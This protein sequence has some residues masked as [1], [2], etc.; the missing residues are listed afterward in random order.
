MKTKTFIKTLLLGMLLVSCGGNGEQTTPS[1]NL[2]NK[3]SVNQENITI[4]PRSKLNSSDVGDPMPFYDNGVMNI[5][6]LENF[7]T[8]G[9]GYHPISLFQTQDY[10]HYDDKGMVI[11]YENSIYSPEVALGTGSVVKKDGIYHFFYTGHNSSRSSGLPYYEKILHA[12]STDLINWTKHPEHGFYGN[13][14]DFRD[15]Y[16]F[17]NEEEQC[18]WMLITTRYRERGVLALYTST[19]PNLASWELKNPEFYVNGYE[20]YNME[21]PTLIKFNGY[22]YLSFSEQGNNRITRYRYTTSLSSTNTNWIVPEIDYFDS[23]GFYAG[24]LEKDENKLYA[25]GWCAIKEGAY[26]LGNFDWGGNLVV[27]ELTQNTY[28]ELQAKMIDSIKSTIKTEVGYKSTTT[29][30]IIKE[31][32]YNNG[33]QSTALERLSDNITRISFKLNLNKSTGV[34]GITFNSNANNR[35][36]SLAYEFDFENNKILFYNDIYEGYKNPPQIEVKYTFSLRKDISCDLIIEDEV[37]ILYVDNTIA[38]T[39]RMYEHENRQFAF[40]GDSGD[41]TIKDVKFYE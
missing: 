29:N 18:Y 17:Y 34:G 23:K 40:Y 8:M 14:N 31:Y 16:V 33:M 39:T 1:I 27:H 4:A 21:C 20:S 25:F 36:G 38:L 19:D 32:T 11:N 30:E 12:T 26:D 7:A 13:H 5:F 22:W 6:Y 2:P 3:G 37:A 28:G 15:P 10:V 35:Y 9:P 24:R 41:F